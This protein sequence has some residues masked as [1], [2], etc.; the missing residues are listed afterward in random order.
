[1]GTENT[2]HKTLPGKNK[3]PINNPIWQNYGHVLAIKS[4]LP[5]LGNRIFN[6]VV[7]SGNCEFKKGKPENV[8]L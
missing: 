8:F 5:F 1:M 7:F 3:Y 4:Q 2:G 6:A